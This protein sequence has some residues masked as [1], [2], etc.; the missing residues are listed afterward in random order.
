MP[1]FTVMIL[2]TELPILEA[3]SGSMT[4]QKS[5]KKKLNVVIKLLETR[6]EI[7]E[8]QQRDRDLKQKYTSATPHSKAVIQDFKIITRAAFIRN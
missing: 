8:R 4:G 7:L 2:E 1:A 3:N 5:N 6:L